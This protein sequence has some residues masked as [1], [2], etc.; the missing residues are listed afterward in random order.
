[1]GKKR[2]HS[3]QLTLCIRERKN[4]KR[5]ICTAVVGLSILGFG[6]FGVAYGNGGGVVQAALIGD[7]GGAPGG[8][9]H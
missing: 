6:I 1:M 2:I 7:Y 4:L 9:G 8:G 5:K 3:F